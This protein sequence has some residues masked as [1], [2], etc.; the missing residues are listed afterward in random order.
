MKKPSNNDRCFTLQ[1]MSATNFLGSLQT[2][3]RDTIN[4]ETVDLLTPYFSPTYTLAEAMRSSADVAGLLSW[5]LAMAQFYWIN[6]KV[7]PLK[8]TSH[9]FHHWP[10]FTLNLLQ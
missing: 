5:T 2:F 3:D 10:T 6:R 9:F 7:L 8:V 4:E 1:L